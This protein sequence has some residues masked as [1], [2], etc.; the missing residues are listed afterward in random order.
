MGVDA[1]RSIS[2]PYS[3]QAPPVRGASFWCIVTSRQ[4]Q[5]CLPGRLE[6]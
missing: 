6:A 1:Y 5:A 3:T 4:F 2:K